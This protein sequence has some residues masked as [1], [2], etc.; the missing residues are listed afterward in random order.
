M[1]KPCASSVRAKTFCRL[2]T[3]GFEK[4]LA[5]I[6]LGDGG[7]IAEGVLPQCSGRITTA[8]S[9]YNDIECQFS[10]DASCGRWAAGKRV[11]GSEASLIQAILS[12]LIRG[13]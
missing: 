1:C 6:Q 4:N 11:L 7:R 9:S 3:E 5:R 8:V 12:K 13:I 10:P 2:P